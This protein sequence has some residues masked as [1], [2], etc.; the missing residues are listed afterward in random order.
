MITYIL[1]IIAFVAAKRQIDTS[2]SHP[3][4]CNDSI[5]QAAADSGL[6]QD[7]KTFVDLTL[8]APISQVLENF[9]VQSPK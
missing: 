2:C 6:F 8:K 7:S 3:I 9:K 5:L 4:F 1:L